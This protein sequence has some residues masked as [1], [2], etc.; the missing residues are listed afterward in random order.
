MCVSQVNFVTDDC[1]DGRLEVYL[2][3]RSLDYPFMSVCGH[4]A[5]TLKDL[6]LLTSKDVEETVGG[7]SS[8]FSGGEP[9]RNQHRRRRRY[10]HVRFV[11]NIYPHKAQFKIAWS[12]LYHLPRGSDAGALHAARRTAAAADVNGRRGDDDCTFPCPG[13]ERLCLPARSVCNGVVNCPGVPND[14]S[15]ATCSAWNLESA[16]AASDDAADRAQLSAVTLFAAVVV[17]IVVFG[18]ALFAASAYCN[19][20][21][22]H[23]GSTTPTTGGCAGRRR[24][25]AG[26]RSSD[27]IYS[28]VR[29]ST[30]DI[31]FFKG[32]FIIFTFMQCSNF[33]AGHNLVA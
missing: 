30:I 7:A 27:R 31:L 23:R 12:A 25:I 3:S 24:S 29:P 4:N 10:V 8:L 28:T 19:R 9:P 21:R 16:A 17:A 1:R 22:R 32:G 33:I 15:P 5:T 11:G 20:R 6:P 14:E 2:P 18:V 13:D 26:T